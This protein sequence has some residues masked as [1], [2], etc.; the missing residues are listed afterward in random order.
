MT[1]PELGMDALIKRL[2]DQAALVDAQDSLA[3]K[4]W[5]TLWQTRLVTIF[6]EPYHRL[7][8]PQSPRLAELL[9]AHLENKSFVEHAYLIL[10]G[11]PSDQQGAIYYQQLAVREGRVAMLVALLQSNEA[12]TYIKQHHLQLP[13]SLLRL[14]RGYRWLVALPGVRQVGLR[15]WRA[16]AS[17]LWRCRQRRWR[18]EAEYYRILAHYGQ[19]QEEHQALAMTLEEMA[20]IQQ[21]IVAQCNAASRDASSLPIQWLSVDQAADMAEILKSAEEALSRKE[22]EAP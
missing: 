22:E 3:I 6:D 19:R 15:V 1:D 13:D 18:E 14:E 5:V 8:E 17:W 11:R 9:C 10:V 2:K 16:F 20:N 7:Y 21:R 12:Q 4:S